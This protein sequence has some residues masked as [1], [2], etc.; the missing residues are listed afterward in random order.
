M[1]RWIPHK[2]DDINDDPTKRE[3]RDIRQDYPGVDEYLQKKELGYRQGEFT[4]PV[5]AHDLI[6]FDIH[7][8]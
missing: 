2:N 8:V 1:A 4:M 7:S 6:N 3:Y 5:H